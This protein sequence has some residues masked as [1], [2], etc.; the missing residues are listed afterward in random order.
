MIATF[1]D[2]ETT[3]KLSPDHRIVEASFRVCDL[4]KF[5]ELEEYC[6]RFNPERHIEAK[7]TAVHG[8]TDAD[9]KSEPLFKERLPLIKT[10]I[11]KTDILIAHNLE[12]DQTFL[13][14]EFE[15]CG[16]T[17]IVKKGFD[18]LTNGT[19]ATDL[20]KLPTLFE[21]CWSLGVDYDA[22]E[23]H[24]AAYDTAVLRDAVFA[25]VKYGWF[26]FN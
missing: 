7:A 24:S 17:L 3:G 9:V 22:T 14:Q 13:E 6:W 18:T 1:F 16:E 12:F 25:A 20:G 5:E 26:D 21:F 4:E 8:I 23:A 15:R 10:I 11:D 19:F 2:F